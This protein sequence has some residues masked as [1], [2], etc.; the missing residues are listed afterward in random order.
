MGESQH[1]NAFS[2]D[3]Y[4]ANTD[5]CG[6]VSLAEHWRGFIQTS[7]CKVEGV[8]YQVLRCKRRLYFNLASTHPLRLL[9]NYMTQKIRTGGEQQWLAGRRREKFWCAVKHDRRL[10]DDKI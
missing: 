6:R 5:V 9:F 3:E 1:V 8:S 2:T 7:I 10:R 4:L